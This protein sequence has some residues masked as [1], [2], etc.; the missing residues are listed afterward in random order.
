[1]GK[2]SIKLG[3]LE[4][5][6]YKRNE[7]I[8]AIVVSLNSRF[9]SKTEAAVEDGASAR[10]PTL[11]G[12]TANACIIYIDRNGREH[13]VGKQSTKLGVPE[14]ATYKRNESISARIPHV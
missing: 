1:M 11:P 8:S 7:S 2:Q 12:P 3:V 5:A 6:T 4:G 9:K 10:Q 13:T 14:E